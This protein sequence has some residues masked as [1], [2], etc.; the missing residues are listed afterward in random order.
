MDDYIVATILIPTYNR[1][2]DL[3]YNLEHIKRNADFERIKFI[4]LDG[5]SVELAATNKQMCFSS[6]IEYYHFGSH[7]TFQ[8]RVLK[9]LEKV[10]TEYVALLADDDLMDFNGFLECVSFLQSHKDYG[11]VH[12]QYVSFY[13]QE[14]GSIS[15][16]GETYKSSSYKE[17]DPLVRLYNHFS[18]F[19]AH[20]LFA[21]MRVSVMKACYQAMI[22]IGYLNDKYLCYE[23]I[24]VA[25]VTVSGK[26]KR[27][28]IHYYKR[29]VETSNSLLQET[30]FNIVAYLFDKDFSSKYQKTKQSILTQLNLSEID[31]AIA[32]KAID[33]SF[34]AYYGKTFNKLTDSY[35]LELNFPEFVFDNRSC[36]VRVLDSVYRRLRNLFLSDRFKL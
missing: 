14:D 35:F 18:D 30:N 26:V 25:I 10:N 27:L 6:N 23:L 20:E 9:G 34:G 8:E 33:I 15:I 36:A 3:F 17:E 4:V 16:I 31:K 7:V 19:H 29:Q 32:D 24:H 13:R 5:S 12:G 11:C 21:V 1:C 22:D 28:P 2:K